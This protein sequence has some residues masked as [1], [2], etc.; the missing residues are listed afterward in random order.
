M[1]YTCPKCDKVFCQK[2][3]YDN[4]LRRKKPCLNI[5]GDNDTSNIY[6]NN[7]IILL[8]HN[9]T[10]KPHNNTQKPQNNTQKPHN[11]T[12]KPIIQQN[13]IKIIDNDNINLNI[14]TKNKCEYCHCIFSRKDALTRHLKNYC[15]EKKYKEKIIILE[16]ENLKLKNQLNQQN[17]QSVRKSK[18]SKTSKISK[19][20]NLLDNTICNITNNTINNCQ[21]IHNQ[22]NNNQNINIKI[23]SFGEEDISKLTDD[24]VLKI[25]KSRNNAFINLIKMVH[26][27]ERLPEFNNILVN[28]LRSK[29][30]TYVDDN[31][32]ISCNKIN[33]MLQIISSRLFDLKD[34]VTK[35]KQ[36]KYL[37]N[38][39]IEV[40]E[41]IIKFSEKFNLEDE[42][43]D[44]N[45]IKIDKNTL[46]KN[47]DFIDELICT[48]YNNRELVEQTLD[49]LTDKSITNKLNNNILDI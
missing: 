22:L 32:L 33:L 24:E 38:R 17:V 11:N 14:S 5:F 19:Q 48:F 16:E 23:V 39:E 37:T 46:K 27:N 7:N 1:I 13:E 31:K 43:I 44:G 28:N 34:L 10:Q 9:N 15:K 30:A 49:T 41:T 20:N 12:Q 3:H 29:Y 47:K 25:L 40:L 45:P 6:E 21:I 4:H 42:D 18:I 8:T 36:T 2:C 26:L 35:Y